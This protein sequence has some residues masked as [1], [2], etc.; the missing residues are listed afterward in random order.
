MSGI[1]PP[2]FLRCISVDTFQIT[3]L[4]FYLKLNI[5]S[6][7]STY[8]GNIFVDANSI[9]VGM[10][11]SNQVNGYAWKIVKI[12]TQN[13]TTI[14]CEVEDVEAFN[15]A[16]DSTG[17]IN[18]ISLGVEGFV[19]ELGDDGL[20]IILPLEENILP[21]NWNIDITSRF[22]S[23]NTYK[24]YINVNQNHYFNIGNFI[25]IDVND[26]LYKLANRDTKNIIG[27]VTSVNIP[28]EDFFTYRPFG[29]YH[30]KNNINPL[31]N[32]TKGQIY[33]IDIDGNVSQVPSNNNIKWIQITDEGDG[34]LFTS[35]NN[36][37]F[38]L[39]VNVRRG[40][41]ADINIETGNTFGIE[42]FD[43]SLKIFSP[44]NI[45]LGKYDSETG[46]ISNIIINHS[47]YIGVNNNNPICELDVKGMTKAT[48]FTGTHATFN[49]NLTV[50]GNAY[51][52]YSQFWNI[53]SDKR[54]KKNIEKLDYK[55]CIESINSIK[56]HK[57]RYHDEYNKIFNSDDKT[58]V[59]VLADE[60]LETH[61][62]SVNVV[63]YQKIGTI[64]MNNFKTI[65]ISQQLYELIGCT[66]YL[67]SE[68]DMLKQII[69]NK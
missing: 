54:I 61:P 2:I 32:G 67:L 19:F 36:S 47:G 31:L 27:I 33:Y 45:L 68:I 5:F 63:P 8:G 49:G 29:L 46:F 20:P 1:I 48:I 21:I 6:G 53:A 11:F 65:D 58:Y 69:K 25:Y 60:L 16:I 9:K 55:D 3:E 17:I 40:F 28:Y 64:E 24:N 43:N 12:L 23:R 10:W 30:S 39:P 66:Q 7:N 57:F 26:G 35:S 18:Y 51:K 41:S 44:T 14:E 56:L 62:E 4:K 22:R 15:I 13:S 50:G 34:L 37:E 59:G 38:K 42:N 52:P